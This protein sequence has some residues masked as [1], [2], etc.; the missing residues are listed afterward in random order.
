MS[1]IASYLENASWRMVV[2]GFV[3]RHFKSHGHAH[4]SL[5]WSH[6]RNPTDWD[7]CAALNPANTACPNLSTVAAPT[8]VPI[9]PCNLAI[10]PWLRPQC[11]LPTCNPYLLGSQQ[12]ECVGPTLQSS[13]PTIAPRLASTGTCPSGGCEECEGICHSDRDCA[14]N[15]ECF[16]RDDLD[17]VPNCG[18]GGIAGE[19]IAAV[20]GHMDGVMVEWLPLFS[21]AGSS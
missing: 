14:G 15:L 17:E 9:G 5:S 21:V 11:Y 20:V 12:G 18:R 1:Y 10:A 13:A 3:A 6:S 7:Y 8:P 2:L 16:K 19:N 4:F